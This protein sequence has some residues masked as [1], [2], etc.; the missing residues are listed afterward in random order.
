MSV[1]LRP[2]LSLG[3]EVYHPLDDEGFPG[4]AFYHTYHHFFADISHLSPSDI[5]SLIGTGIVVQERVGARHVVGPLVFLDCLCWPARKMGARHHHGLLDFGS[6]AHRQLREIL[7]LSPRDT[8]CAR[9][10]VRYLCLSF[11]PV[12]L[13][14]HTP[15]HT[16]LATLMFHFTGT[17]HWNGSPD[18]L[19]FV[20]RRSNES[21]VHW[22]D[23]LHLH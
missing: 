16:Y 14:K 6:K 13:C 9:F 20:L 18:S 21:Q 7:G 8:P 5:S 12:F 10:S 1:W 19:R 17:G 23:N 4:P 11:R 22:R 2:S 15:S 3:G